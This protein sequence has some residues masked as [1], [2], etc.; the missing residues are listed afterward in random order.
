MR[1]SSG[2]RLQRLPISLS[3]A[4]KQASH[5]YKVGVPA[6]IYDSEAYLSTKGSVRAGARLPAIEK[7][8]ATVH[9][10]GTPLIRTGTL[11][12]IELAGSS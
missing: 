6:Y 1:L 11:L 5:I 8:K 2:L 9:L 7:K 3:R 4:L 10:R 12:I